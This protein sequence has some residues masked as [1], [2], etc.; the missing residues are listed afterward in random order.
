[1]SRRERHKRRTRHR[2]HPVRKVIVMFCVLAVCGI[3]VGALAAVG[4]VVAVADSAPNLAQLKPR[5]P[6]PLVRGLRVRRHAARLHPFGHRSYVNVVRQPD[7]AHAQGRDG[8]DRGPPL[9][10]ARG[11]RL[12][13]HPPRR[14]QGRVRQ[15]QLPAGRL[16]ADDAARRQHVHAGRHTPPTTT[17]STRSS[18][19]SSPSS[20]RAS[21]A[22]P[23]SSTRT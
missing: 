20:S 21:T 23:G 19:P 4:W 22:R 2:G 11:A 3:A 16:D 13:G 8:G 14:D 17:S 6:H 9:L 1:M 10:A 15:R 7:P 18:R 12:P 5:S